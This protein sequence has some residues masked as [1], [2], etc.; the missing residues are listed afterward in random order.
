MDCTSPTFLWDRDIEAERFRAAVN[1][2]EDPNHDR[3]LALLLR[4]AR[5]D[6]VWQWTTPAHVSEHLERLAPCLGRRREFWLWTFQG[7]RRLGLVA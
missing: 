3:W 4:E 7:W 5:P 6:E 1:D 2:P